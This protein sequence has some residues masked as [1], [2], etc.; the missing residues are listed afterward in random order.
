MRLGLKAR[1][2]LTSAALIC[3]GSLVL[4]LFLQPIAKKRLV[5]QAQAE[6][7]RAARL[8]ALRVATLPVTATI[9]AVDQLVDRLE[10]VA[11]A[12][13]VVLD[14]TGRLRGDSARRAAEIAADPIPANVPEGHLV[15]EVPLYAERPAEGSV[16]LSVSAAWIDAEL[17]WIWAVIVL[18]AGC[19]LGGAVYLTGL[20]GRLAGRALAEVASRA[21]V[22]DGPAT[23]PGGWQD[24][25]LAV[26]SVSR[27]AEELS[28]TIDVLAEERDRFRAVVESL[29]EA[30]LVFGGDR[31][32]RVTNAAARR[33]LGL[34]EG[35]VGRSVLETTRLPALAELVQ[36]ALDGSR[37]ASTEVAL[38]GAPPR[39]A[40]ARSA[41]LGQGAILVLR[42]VTDLRRLESMRK[43][44]VANVSHELRTPIAIVRANAEALLD[45]GLADPQR[46]QLFLEALARNAERL[47]RLVG[48]LL[49]ISRLEAGET[50]LELRAVAIGPAVARV[51]AAVLPLAEQKRLQLEVD[52]PD[53]LVARADTRAL[54]QVLTNLVDNAVK[55][56]PDGGHIVVHAAP[57]GPSHCTIAV[58]D[59]GPGIAPRHRPRL[60]ERFYR[61]DAGR[62][63]EVGGTGLGLAI[64]KHLVEAMGG[65]VGVEPN[66]P[67]GS[68]F[69]VTLRGAD[70]TSM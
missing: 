36:G 32:L 10:A 66:T 69:T 57:D 56:T 35:A 61:V 37:S 15:S 39:I 68:K 53:D 31:R 27:L 3:G 64:V 2:L 12:H 49:D 55:Y 54:D 22:G 38:Q 52:V 46:A 14:A 16:R 48:D 7:D 42:E 50:R 23:T 47:G 6:L 1:L 58:L 28:A 65:R 17:G 21:R 62:S 51:V 25:S 67:R 44:I 29:E 5:A 60:F 11:D 8:A 26:D 45:G 43:D 19:G 18:A 63:R 30:V 13:V 40:L 70:T 59:D 9:A 41:P 33:L 20:A 34:A 4:G 24:L